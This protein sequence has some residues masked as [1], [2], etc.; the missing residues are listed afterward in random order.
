MDNVENLMMIMQGLSEQAVNYKDLL[1]DTL[2]KT[3]KEY[4]QIFDTEYINF[5][6]YYRDRMR[7]TYP[8]GMHIESRC[9]DNSM[10]YAKTV[11][12][13]NVKFEKH[14]GKIVEMTI[15]DGDEKYEITD[16]GFYMLCEI[17][18]YERSLIN[19]ILIMIAEK[20]NRKRTI[21]SNFEL[22]LGVWLDICTDNIK[23][24]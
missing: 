9:I 23:T 3:L 19:A 16:F 12:I 7:T 14:T 10:Q 17:Y 20:T 1:E 13:K 8:R 2:E 24:K 11:L 15:S 6:D 18:D 22:K 4:G 5:D 21:S